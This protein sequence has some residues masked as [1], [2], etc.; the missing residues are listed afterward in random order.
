MCHETDDAE[1]NLVHDGNVLTLRLFLQ[2]SIVMPRA[3]LFFVSA[4]S[5]RDFSSGIKSQNSAEN[6]VDQENFVWVL[7]VSF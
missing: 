2:L 4:F 3:I 6:S 7:W 5:M 1:D